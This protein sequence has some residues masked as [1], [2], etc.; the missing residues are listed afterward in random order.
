M[1]LSFYRDWQK[2]CE[3]A[4]KGMPLKLA[5]PGQETPP[6]LTASLEL[7]EGMHWADPS[8][9]G[10]AAKHVTD[11]VIFAGGPVWALDFCPTAENA[12]SEYLVVSS[13]GTPLNDHPMGASR[14]VHRFSTGVKLW[15]LPAHSSAKPNSSS[16]AFLRLVWER[17]CTFLFIQTQPSSV[18]FSL[19]PMLY[20]ETLLSQEEHFRGVLL[21]ILSCVVNQGQISYTLGHLVKSNHQSD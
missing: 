18:Q 20:S 15:G 19:Y 17:K 11:T 7:F 5:A 9:K 2:H 21:F 6:K 1:T 12:E 16:N 8:A 13:P 4:A 10:A 3:Y 14:H